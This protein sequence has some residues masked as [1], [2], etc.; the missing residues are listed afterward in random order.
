MDCNQDVTRI[1][2]CNQDVTRIFEP[3]SLQGLDCLEAIAAM[4]TERGWKDEGLHAELKDWLLLLIRLVDD[5][6]EIDDLEVLLARK[7]SLS[8]CFYDYIEKE[9]C[10]CGAMFSLAFTV[11]TC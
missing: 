9:V 1:L 11:A 3:S 6:S 10:T 5:T 4:Y 7:H 8:Q 2:D